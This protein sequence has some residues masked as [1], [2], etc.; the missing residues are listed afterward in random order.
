MNL[1][2]TLRLSAV[3]LLAFLLI[4]SSP[5]LASNSFKGP[6]T[7]LVVIRSLAVAFWPK[8]LAVNTM[9]I[10]LKK[11]VVTTLP[12]PAVEVP[13]PAVLKLVPQTKLLLGVVLKADGQPLPGASVYPAGAPRQ[14][15][16]T[17]AQGHFELH[18]AKGTAASLWVEYF[19][20]GSSRVEVPASQF[21]PLQITLG[22]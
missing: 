11:P 13:T 19:G 9:E 17:D 4:I 8:V 16:V 14:L 7:R 15:V 3:T 10:G 22:Q 1:T 2:T 6:A 21:T 12:A 20:E 18:V 5:A